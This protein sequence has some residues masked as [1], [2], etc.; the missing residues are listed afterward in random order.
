LKFKF[1]KV[2][3]RLEWVATIEVK[4]SAMPFDTPRYTDDKETSTGG[5][6]EWAWDV[7]EVHRPVSTPVSI[8][9]ARSALELEAE[10]EDQVYNW[11]QDDFAERD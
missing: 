1:R 8:A 3:E 10:F 5:V 11:C 6:Y 9:M 7:V 2:I 4:Y